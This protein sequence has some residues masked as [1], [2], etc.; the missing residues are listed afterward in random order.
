MVKSPTLEIPIA[1]SIVD[2]MQKPAQ[3]QYSIYGWALVLAES[4]LLG[5]KKKTLSGPTREGLDQ[6]YRFTYMNPKNLLLIAGDIGR[7]FQ[8]VS[9]PLG[10]L[11]DGIR[12]IF[13]SVRLPFGAVADG[14]CRVVRR[15]DS[16]GI[17]ADGIGRVFP[18]IRL[19]FGVVTDGIRRVFLGI[20]SVL[21]CVFTSVFLRRVTG[22]RSKAEKG[23]AQKGN[24][25]FHLYCVVFFGSG[26]SGFR[27][28]IAM[29]VPRRFQWWKGGKQTHPVQL[30]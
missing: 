26:S 16:V 18:G 28:Y 11:A 15:I 29:T 2:L 27:F 13:L 23:S 10:I 30:A 20:G 22:H 9:F 8:V 1:R 17:V 3:S 25:G 5:E 6:V 21:Q 19:P 12:R 24:N 7:I 14:I 4:I